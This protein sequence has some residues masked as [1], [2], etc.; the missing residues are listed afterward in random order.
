MIEVIGVN[1]LR[2]KERDGIDYIGREWAGWEASPLGNPYKSVPPY[3]RWLWAE[4]RDAT[5]AG[6]AVYA[7]AERARAGEDIKLGCWC[8]SKGVDAPCHGDVVKAAMEWI[9]SQE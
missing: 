2:E 1:G 3:R 5:D 8:K 7:L 4:M 9:I 6:R